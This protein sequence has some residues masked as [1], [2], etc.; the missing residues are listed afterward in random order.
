MIRA[1]QGSACPRAAA[2]LLAAAVLGAARA[3][4]HPHVFVDATVAPVF[5]EAERFTAVH[6]K[7][8]FDIAFTEGI[9]P[10]LDV[11]KDGVLSQSEIENAGGVGELWF[12]PYDYF[13]R[14]TV[15]GRPVDRKAVEGFGVRIADARL[16][17]EFTVPLSEPAVI[18]LGAGIDVFDPEFYVDVEFADPGI[19]TA[20]V[21]ASCQAA[22]RQTPNLD[23][24]AAMIIRKLGLPADPSLLSDPAAGY[25]VRIALDCK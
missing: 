2:A 9:G 16:V 7:W 14:I 23:P 12:I 5:D 17:V 24:V 13:T 19:D 18:T 3:E 25:P 22:R 10:D 11:N 21:P 20:S 4:A 1:P 6:E 15:A 8:A